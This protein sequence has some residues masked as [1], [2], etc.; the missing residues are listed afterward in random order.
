MKWLH[1]VK[2]KYLFTED[3]DHETIQKVMNTI[4]DVLERE[5]CFKK[6]NAKSFR[7]IPKGN[8]DFS[9]CDY[10]NRRLVRMWDF[11]DRHRIWIE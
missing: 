8:S 11:A 7:K 9:A 6:F 3:E 1:K 2:I 5:P 4:A 10:A